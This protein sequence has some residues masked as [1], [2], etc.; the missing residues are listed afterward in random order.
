MAADAA[1]LPVVGHQDHGGVVELA[2]FVEEPQ[3]IA[4]LAVGFRELV[5]VLPAAHAADVAELIGRQ[6]L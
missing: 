2:A 1:S 3:E 5:E 4:Y 6:Q